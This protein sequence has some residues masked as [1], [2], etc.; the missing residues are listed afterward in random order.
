MSVRPAAPL[1]L[2]ALLVVPTLLAGVCVGAGPRPAPYGAK[3]A[4]RL[5]SPIRFAD[6]DLT[7]LGERRVE[8]DRYPRGFTVHDFRVSRDDEGVTVSWSAGTGDVG[9]A[10]FPFAGRSFLLELRRS[11]RLGPLKTDELVV[12]PAET[13]R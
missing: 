2:H 12:T 7:Y 9:P 1:L 8:T 11:D 3:V 5:S 10:A 13:A 6:F 4:F